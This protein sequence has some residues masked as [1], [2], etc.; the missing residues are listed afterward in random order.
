MAGPPQKLRAY[1]KVNIIKQ[2]RKKETTKHS[3]SA[4]Y[5]AKMRGFWFMGSLASFQVQAQ[6]QI[7]IIS[8]HPS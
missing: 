8:K 4:R 1:A 3:I 6:V 7:T 5:R 2:E